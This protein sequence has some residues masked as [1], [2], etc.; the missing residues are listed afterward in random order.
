MDIKN[1]SVYNYFHK[2]FFFLLNIAVGGNWPGAPNNET[3]F[4]QKMYVD[5][6]RVYK[7]E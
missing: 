7:L 5:Y 1:S 4:P 3:V 2:N 6:I